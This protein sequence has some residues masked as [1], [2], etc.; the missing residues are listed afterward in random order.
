[1]K[2][3][4]LIDK[5]KRIYELLLVASTYIIHKLFLEYLCDPRLLQLHGFQVSQSA[6]PVP[7]TAGPA[8]PPEHATSTLATTLPDTVPST[9]RLTH[10]SVLWVFGYP[11]K[12]NPLLHR[13]NS[14]RRYMSIIVVVLKSFYQCYSFV[15]S[16]SNFS[17]AL[18]K[19][20]LFTLYQISTN[21]KF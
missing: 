12:N 20:K 8:P 21:D 5:N 7:Q 1:M 17:Y 2:W 3:W 6:G 15:G 14:L 13:W 10:H 16:K 19:G 11:S 9:K 4:D 18:F